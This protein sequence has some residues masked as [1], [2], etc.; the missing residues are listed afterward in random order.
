MHRVIHFELGAQEPERAVKFYQDVF[1]WKV[2]K[3]DGPTPYW[4]VTTGEDSQPG[5][6]GGIMR[7]QDGGAR[8]VN[9][10]GV[11]SVG[12]F[13]AR[14]TAGGGQIAMPKFPI[15]GI[16]WQAYCLDTEGNLFGIHQADP[17]AK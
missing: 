6:N 3:W 2:T 12:D 14:V 8:T 16:G 13:L 5:I 11:E 17:S 4:L 15:P 10:I 7:H 9:T 1:G